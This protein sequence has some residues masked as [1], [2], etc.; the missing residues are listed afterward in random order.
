MKNEV[1]APIWFAVN[2]HAP[3]LYERL[4][5]E[6][7]HH[8]AVSGELKLYALV[9]AAFNEKAIP[10]YRKSNPIEQLTSLYAGTELDGLTDVSP[11]IVPLSSKGTLFD[12]KIKTLLRLAN[13]KPMLSFL[14]SSLDAQS[15]KEHFSPF[16]QVETEDGQQFV[17]RF[18]DTRILPAL[19]ATLRNEQQ[20]A[21][22]SPIVH[23]WSINRKGELEALI[24]QRQDSARQSIPSV[25][26]SVLPISN[27]QLF[28]LLDAAEADSIIEQLRLV[29][30]EQCAGYEPAE[31]HRFVS[32]QLRYAQSFKVESVADLVAYCIG[33]FNTEGKLHE[34]RHAKAM[35]EERLW[36]PG[37][38][39]GA[40]AEL[41]EEC[42]TALPQ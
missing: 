13:G 41:P 36:R 30:P 16:L 21:F 40:L 32:A 5:Q 3:E 8:V 7:N 39:A 28:D 33:S 31:L 17:L 18:A 6:M 38:L 27:S 26:F 2:R 15:L 42:W 9:D 22:L 20:E 4:M 34:N 19:I 35:L 37:D 10:Q 23:W 1:S 12:T 14:A 24:S 11:C 25:S 29:T